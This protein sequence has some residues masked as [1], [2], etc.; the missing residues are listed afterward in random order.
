MGN[1][2]DYTEETIKSLKELAKRLGISDRF[3]N[4][5]AFIRRFGEFAK[6]ICRSSESNTK[7][8]KLYSKREMDS[9]ETFRIQGSGD[10]YR[11]KDEIMKNHIGRISSENGEIGNQQ[12][13]YIG[14]NKD[15][16]PVVSFYST[17]DGIRRLN[18]DSFTL[19]QESTHT[20]R[21][22]L[23]LL[24]REQEIDKEGL[25]LSEVV[26]SWSKDGRIDYKRKTQYE[27][28]KM[29]CVEA[30]DFRDRPVYIIEYYET[31]ERKSI[32]Q[33][34]YDSKGMPLSSKYEFYKDG[35]M[36]RADTGS[37]LER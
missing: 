31:G 13:M 35:R 32:E 15:G 1:N 6:D 33:I 36:R 23:D 22:I 2:S 18:V 27:D 28:G 21:T 17:R 16:N 3:V 19:G 30:S 34:R 12:T 11:L 37:D 9:E 8:R 4:N 26:T 24:E 5:L 25:P 7:L 29:T 10:I 14:S 20:R